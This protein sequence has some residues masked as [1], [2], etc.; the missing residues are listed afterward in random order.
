[1]HLIAPRIAVPQ[2][3]YDHC[4]WKSIFRRIMDVEYHW[5]QDSWLWKKY[6][7]PD[8]VRHKKYRIE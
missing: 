2:L 4:V 8:D 6:F 1:M 7:S 3:S 5:L